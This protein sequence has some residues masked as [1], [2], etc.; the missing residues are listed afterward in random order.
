MNSLL[1]KSITT[2]LYG[3]SQ[4]GVEIELIVR[5]ICCL[6]P[7]IKGLIENI[8]VSISDAKIK[9]LRMSNYEF[10]HRVSEKFL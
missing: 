6:K 10:W 8:K 1:D 7:G 4:A 9:L 3:A 5:C 2:E